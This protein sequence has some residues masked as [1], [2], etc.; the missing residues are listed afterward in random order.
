MDLDHDGDVDEADIRLVTPGVA[1]TLY[2]ADF[3]RAVGGDGLPGP[4]GLAAFDSAV[5]C[6]S[7]RAARW[8][9]AAVGAAQDGKV[10]PL[11]LQAAARTDLRQAIA[12]LLILRTD[13]LRGLRPFPTF[14][15]G[16]LRR[17]HLLDMAARAWAAEVD[18]L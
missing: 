8:L 4:L 17:I 5:L 16:W 7:P 15:R 9:Q 12:D 10:G 1:R 11:T 6:G 3:W 13:Y 14:G 18:A 2:R